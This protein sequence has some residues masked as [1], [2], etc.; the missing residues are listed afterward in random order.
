MAEKGGCVVSDG[1]DWL[2]RASIVAIVGLV[3][4][5]PIWW[6]YHKVRNAIDWYRRRSALKGDAK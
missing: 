4:L 5:F 3:V 1:K 6:P 2:G